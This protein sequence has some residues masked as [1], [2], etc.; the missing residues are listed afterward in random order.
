MPTDDLVPLVRRTLGAGN[1]LGIYLHGSA[2]LGG[3]RPYSDIDVLAVVRHP[4]TH[5]QRRSLVEELLRV[6]GG[7]GQ[8][9]LELTVVVQGEVRPWRYP[10]NCEFQYG[11][12]LRDDYERGLV[13]D[14]GPMPDLA[15][16][17]TMVLQG[18]APLY[19]PPPAALLDPVPHGDLTRAIVAGVPQLMDE[20]DSDTR[21]VLLTLARV[22]TTLATGA[23]RSKDTA[24]DWVLRRLPVEQ[25]P[26]LTWARD[27]Y[28]GVQREAPSPEGVRGCAD[29]MVQEIRTLADQ[30]SYGPPRSQP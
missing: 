14:P 12:W 6:S 27:E 11:E 5:D 16:L 28:L 25:S 1:V 15:P 20:L 30:P 4:T 26:A 3:L 23:I 24:A 19:G 8:R 22:W 7:E 17:L 2:T 18:D 10:P 29:A 13:P 9:P 21:N